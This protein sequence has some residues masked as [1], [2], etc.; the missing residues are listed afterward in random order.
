[1]LLKTVLMLHQNIILYR[2]KEPYMKYHVSALSD[3]QPLIRR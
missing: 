1:M 2:K 3:Y